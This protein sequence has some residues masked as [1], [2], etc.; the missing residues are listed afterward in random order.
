M[1]SDVCPFYL[2]DENLVSNL[3]SFTSSPLLLV[4]DDE[5]QIFILLKH[6]QDGNRWKRRLETMSQ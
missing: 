6:I 5:S 2:A 3:L 1:T 4:V